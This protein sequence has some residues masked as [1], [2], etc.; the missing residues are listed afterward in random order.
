MKKSKIREYRGE[1]ISV[2]YDAGRCIHEAECVR[3]LPQVF[4]VEKRPWIDPDS[5]GA[6]RLAEVVCRCPTG[7]LKFQR[8]DGGPSE[9]AAEENAI[10]IGADGPLY[11]E[12][13]LII[14]DSEGQTLL[15]DTRIAFCRCGASRNKPFCDGAHS[16]ASFRDDGKLTE[17]VKVRE[18]SDGRGPLK[19]R[20]RPDGPLLIDGPVMV[21]SADGSATLVV[22]GGALCRCGSSQRKPFCDGAHRA[23]G[24][25]D[26]E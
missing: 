12:G 7:A 23:I 10:R 25:T 8:S 24:F 4:D 21:S 9:S 19:I 2:Q 13:D 18:P 1:T 6:D 11:L 20:M 22:G 3:E 15:R 26:Q 14:E 16:R 17:P 5:A